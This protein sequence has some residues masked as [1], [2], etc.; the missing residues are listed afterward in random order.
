[1]SFLFACV[2]GICF[3][4]RAVTTCQLHLTPAS[5]LAGGTSMGQTTGTNSFLSSDRASIPQSCVPQFKLSRRI[6]QPSLFC[7]V[8]KEQPSFQLCDKSC[9]VMSAAGQYA[10]GDGF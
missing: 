1:M 10:T 8:G 9:Q 7:Q 2:G 4:Y 3:L 5:L 6:L